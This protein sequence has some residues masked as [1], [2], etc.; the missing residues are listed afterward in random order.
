MLW[1]KAWRESRIRFL[2]A[3]VTM[4]VVGSGF[5]VQGLPFLEENR[6][7]EITYTALV[8]SAVYGSTF[9]LLFVIMSLVLGLGGLLRERSA[10]TAPF[11]L[12][13]P[14]TR[15]ALT[16]VRAAAG[17]SQ[18]ATLALLPAVLIPALSPVVL[19]ETYPLD[20]ALLFA[21]RWT[22]WGS[23]FFSIGFLWSTLIPSDY[24]AAVACVLTPFVYL[25]VMLT[26]AGRED[27]WPSANFL[28]FMHGSRAAEVPVVPIVV[29][30][31]VC[32]T[33]TVAAAAITSRRDF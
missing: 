1:H 14:V 32:A 30:F 31:M 28:E 5:L 6:S 27:R 15:R 8:D 29:M 10:A 3:L 33:L 25:P 22:A 13:L 9:P 17:L 18:V 19:G 4:A 26:V 21:L 23:V 16:A 24:T 2:V 7:A 20:R 12:A 11:T